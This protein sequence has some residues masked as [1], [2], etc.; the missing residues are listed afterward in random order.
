MKSIVRMVMLS[1]VAVAMLVGSVSAQTWNCGQY[2]DNV[3]ATKNGGTLTISG[4]GAMKDYDGKALE[5]R[6]WHESR[7]TIS[8]IVI[9][10]GVATIGA[11]AFYEFVEITSIPIPNSITSIGQYAIGGCVNMMSIDVASGNSQYSSENGVLFS[12]D[13]TTLIYYPRSKQG[14]YSIPNGVVNIGDATFGSSAFS[15]SKK[16]TSITIPNSVRSITNSAFNQCNALTSV[17][18]GDGVT[19][20][21][22]EA[23][24]VCT[25]LTSVTIPNS[26]NSI[27]KSAFQECSGLT[28][29]TIGSNVAVIKEW[30]FAYCPNLK[31]IT[32]LN[33]NPPQMHIELPPQYKMFGGDNISDINGAFSPNGN[34]NTRPIGCLYVPQGT[35][36]NYKSAAYWKEFP[37]I[38][39]TSGSVSSQPATT[40]RD[41]NNYRT[42]KIGNKTWMAENLNVKTGNSWCYNNGEAYCQ[43][44]G[45]LYD[46]NTAK[47]ICPKGMRLPSEK[48]FD[49]LEKAVG[50]DKVAAKRLK[51][52]SG[53]SNNGN[54]TDDYGFSA[55][56]SGYL[57]E[58]KYEYGGMIGF[59]WTATEK[60]RSGAVGAALVPDKPDFQL[61]QDIPKSAGLPVR[62]VS[63]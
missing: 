39:T 35:V 15:G 17:N 1:A 32:C 29:V 48:D 46:W 31:T 50:G 7:G 52:R 14:A 11:Y 24:Q 34:K 21:G 28:S 25:G 62:C 19:S 51:Y 36:E 49:E 26:V 63:D 59:W 41:D 55:L 2:G 8:K 45:R 43:K 42:V 4:R 18:F 12:K 44:Y 9:N 60:G 33:V 57:N 27:G 47:S 54:G 38:K 23:F 16:L 40:T 58:G 61:I 13:K 53:W 5:S 37:C 30:A 6:P 22:D 3:T 20:I 10:D 56:P